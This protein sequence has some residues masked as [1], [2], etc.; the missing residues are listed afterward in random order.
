MDIAIS[1][2]KKHLKVLFG[3]FAM[4]LIYFYFGFKGG[5]LNKIWTTFYPSDFCINYE[6]GFIR[7][8]L[9]GQII[10]ILIAFQYAI[11]LLLSIVA[12]DFS[13]SFFLCSFTTLI[14]VYILKTKSNYH[15]SVSENS[16]SFFKKF[17]GFRIF[18]FSSTRNYIAVGVLM[19]ILFT[20][21]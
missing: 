4:I 20:T 21:L 5:N 7:S 15:N 6:E 11:L 13:R 12:K 1:Y 14:A 17:T 19:N 10:Y 9:D 3:G 18:C 2:I 16:F 8:G